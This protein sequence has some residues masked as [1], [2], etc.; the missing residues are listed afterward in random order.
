MANDSSAKPSSSGVGL[1]PEGKL[2]YVA[3]Q[4]QACCDGMSTK[5]TCPYC[6]AENEQKNEALCCDLMGKAVA[7]VIDRMET[8]DLLDQTARVAEAVYKAGCN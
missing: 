2:Q 1:T 4:I 3:A 7:A 8:Q 6:G 5:I